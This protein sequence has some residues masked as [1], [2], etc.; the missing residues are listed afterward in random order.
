MKNNI[1]SY[2]L[3]ANNLGWVIFF[4]ALIIRGTYAVIA[5][6]NN[7]MENFGD[8]AFYYEIAN[9]VANQGNFF[10]ET[11]DWRFDKIGPFLP[12]INALII[13]IFGSNWIYIFLVTAIV[14]AGIT[15]LIYHIALLIADKKAAIIAGGWAV[16]YIYYLR[17]VPTAGK[18]TWMAFLLALVV[19]LLVRICKKPD[20][21]LKDLL[22]MTVV[23]VA[24]IHLD[25]RFVVFAPFILLYLIYKQF[26]NGVVARWKIPAIFVA[27]TVL[28]LIPW[29][30]RN[31]QKF[32]KPVIMTTRTER[33]SD[34]LLGIEHQKRKADWFYDTVNIYHI[35][36]SQ[37]DSVARGLKT[38]TDGGYL[39]KPIQR[40]A[41]AR[42]YYPEKLSS[43]EAFWMRLKIL[44]RPFQWGGEYQK[45][46]YFYVEY[47]LKHNLASF[48]F[49]GLMF[50]AAFPGFWWLYRNKREAF[51]LLAGVIGVYVLVHAMAVPWTTERYRLPIAAFFIIAGSIGM[52]QLIEQIKVR[53]LKK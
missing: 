35:K 5:Y 37:Y 6:S 44:L 10:Y 39:I 38:H 8:D 53:I 50:F 46:G 7:V 17:Y 9:Y 18:D 12:W 24:S 43:L 51:Y 41:I 25:E 28:L 13:S 40:R 22:L 11:S 14:S 26:V 36:P 33:I 29:N 19:Y 1:K 23:Y 20:R 48:I 21:S 31:Y 27:L 2:L 45:K 32:E 4:V 3:K 49:Y 42:G 34:K 47:S 16:F 30:W 52:S 15:F